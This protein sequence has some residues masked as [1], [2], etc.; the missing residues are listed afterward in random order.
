MRLRLFAPIAA[1][2]AALSFAAAP[3]AETIDA[4]S[5]G[6]AR[7]AVP[8]GAILGYVTLFSDAG[9][10]TAD[11]ELALTDIAR[12]GALAVG[13]DVKVYLANLQANRNATR[14]ADCVDFFQDVED[15]SR[16]AQQLHP[17]A[18]YNLPII[19]GIGEGGAIAYAALA[20]APADVVSGAISLDPAPELGV[21]R[22][23]CRLPDFPVARAGTR[24]LGS[25]A[26]LHGDW[27]AAFDALA[28]PDGRARVEAIAREGAPVA[29]TA[30]PGRDWTA[31]LVN[32]VERRLAASAAKGVE[33]L[34]LVPLPAPRPSPV[35]A[36]FLS[37]DGGWRDLDK[38]VGEQLQAMGVPV[39]GWDSLR[40]FWRRKTPERTAADLAAA[41]ATYGRKWSA[42]RFALIG[43]SFGADVLP[44]VYNL[45]PPRYR[46]KVAMISLLGLETKADWQIRIAGWFGAPPS[47]AATPLAP[48]FAKISPG[49]IQCIYGVEEKD[50]ACL[51]LASSGAELIETPGEH[52]FGHDYP[53]L[54][55]DLIDGLRRRGAL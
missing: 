1:L 5:F 31:N 3:R 48:E 8:A 22:P 30:L 13:I 47:A 35:I 7:I 23:L 55:K 12:A 6:A 51:S 29:V 2:L 10:W 49:L 33:S 15:L 21:D 36:I 20:Q 11:D 34:P 9:G 14:K 45:L 40:Y 16:Q 25:V 26:T 27:Q 42:E 28:A 24:A 38:T 41:M 39:V 53:A 46:D 50:P 52:H 17:S 32:L 37:G 44:V 4:A 18:F 19:A 43:Y 54:A